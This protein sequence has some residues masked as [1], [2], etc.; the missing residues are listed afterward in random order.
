QFQWV[1]NTT[2]VSGD[3]I[4]KFGVDARRAYNLRVPSDLHRS[5]EL[6]F[7]T[8]RTRGVGGGGLG[9][10]TLL[11]GDVTQFGR[12]ISSNTDARERQWRHFYYGQDTWR[13]T[14]K[15]TENYGLRLDVINPQSI[16]KAGN[17]GFLDLNTGEIMVAGV[18][19]TSLSG[20]VENSLNFA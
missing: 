4:I 11:L 13:A 8:G 5:G 14:P 17:G 3:H 15:L 1:T 10:A 9:L 7:E 16:N 6:T 20:N 19:D 12:Y 18:G 2:K